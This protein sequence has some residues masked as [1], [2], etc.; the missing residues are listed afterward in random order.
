MEALWQQERRR[1]RLAGLGG[2]RRRP[3]GTRDA[4]TGL[5]SAPAFRAV[6][7]Y[8]L[9]RTTRVGEAS[10]LVC[11]ALPV[12]PDE[13]QLEASRRLQAVARRL[14]QV[15][16][17]EDVLGRTGPL[18]L[19]ALLPGVDTDD[20]ELVAGRLAPLEVAVGWAG[21]PAVP[22]D[23]HALLVGA[24][25]EAVRSL[26]LGGQAPIELRDGTDAS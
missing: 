5:M 16:R 8:A 1:L 22:G 20:A 19:S 13:R 25:A 3:E 12:P 14:V 11:C 15:T 10:V 24:R 26:K 9:G 21:V 7:A 17:G 4:L 23:V 18:E 2:A 6:A